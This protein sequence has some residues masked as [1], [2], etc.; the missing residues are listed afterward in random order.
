MPRIRTTI[1]QIAAFSI[2]AAQ[3]LCGCV[4]MPD[5]AIAVGL[6]DASA[7]AEKPPCHGDNTETTTPATESPDDHDCAHCQS[8]VSMVT[9]ADAPA[10]LPA[11]QS[12]DPEFG[13]APLSIARAFT[14]LRHERYRGPPSSPY[15]TSPETLV[16]LNILLLI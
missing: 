9:V 8:E 16:S 3:L 15:T 12:A 13:P 11:N 6:H 1:A 2:V 5:S 7:A 14:P 10:A 4:G